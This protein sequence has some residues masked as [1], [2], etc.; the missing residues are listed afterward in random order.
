[1]RCYNK[2]AIEKNVKASDHVPFDGS[3]SASA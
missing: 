3:V 2:V 1:M